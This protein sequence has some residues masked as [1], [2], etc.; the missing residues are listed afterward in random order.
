MLIF[1]RNDAFTPV[2]ST[3]TGQY[4]IYIYPPP[5]SPAVSLMTW[6]PHHRMSLLRQWETPTHLSWKHKPLVGAGR[7]GWAIVDGE[8]ILQWVRLFTSVLLALGLIGIGEDLS[9]A[10]STSVDATVGTIFPAVN[11]TLIEATHNSL[12][13]DFEH[14]PNVQFKSEVNVVQLKKGDTL[15]AQ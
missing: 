6:M 14:N 3:T 1:E 15:D 10:V 12:S 4:S 8:H 2:F 11:T 9:S 7:G 5:S 13:V